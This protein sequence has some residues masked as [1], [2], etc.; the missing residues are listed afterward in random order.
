MKPD[1]TDSSSIA[2]ENL[3]LQTA[4]RSRARRQDWF[5]GKE[6]SVSEGVAKTSFCEIIHLINFSKI[7]YVI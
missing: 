6:V 1:G 7:L 3:L 5:R 4:P 2:N